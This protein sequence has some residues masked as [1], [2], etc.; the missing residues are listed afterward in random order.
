M[1]LARGAH[2]GIRLPARRAVP[3]PR[4]IGPSLLVIALLSSPAIRAGNLDK[5]YLFNI[6]SQRLDTALLQFGAQTHVQISFASKATEGRAWT[7]RLIGNYTGQKALAELLRGSHLGFVVL[8]N[9]IEIVPDTSISSKTPDSTPKQ[10]DPISKKTPSANGLNGPHPAQPQPTNPTT[11][12]DS[13]NKPALKEIVITGSRLPTS[14]EYGPQEVQIYGAL[15]LD[16]S[17]QTSI[18]QFLSTLPGVSV[19]SPEIVTNYTSTVRLRGLPIGT[20]LVLLD[21]R[22]IEQSGIANGGYFDLS[23]IPMAAI[24]T[25]EVDENG[26]SA[27]YGSDALA[28]VVNIIL[29]NNLDGFSANVKYGWAKDLPYLHTNLAFGRQWSQGGWSVLG[30][31]ESDGT[32]LNSERALS[33]SNDYSNFGGPNNNYPECAPGNVFSTSGSALPGAPAGSGA[34]YAAISGLSASGKPALSQFTYGSLNQCSLLA[35]TSLLPE[36]RRAA[37]LLRGHLEITSSLELF[38]ETLYTHM[39]RDAAVGYADLFGIPGYQQ[40]TVSPSNPYNPFGTTVGVG[41]ALPDVPLP[42]DFDTDFFRPLVGLKGTVADRWQWE[43]SGWQSSDWTRLVAPNEFPNISAIQAALNSSNPAMALN[44]FVTGPIGSQTLIGSLFGDETA[45]AMGRDR[46]AEF[47]VRGAM[48]RLPA[49]SVQAV[50]G[51]DYARSALYENAGGG[52]GV[53]AS[54]N[55]I[56]YY[57]RRYSAVFGE[58]QIP[59]L[60][61]YA[62]SETQAPLLIATI[63]GRHDQYSDFGGATTEQYGLEIRPA[64]SVLVRATY[65]TAFDAPSLLDLY[66]PKQTVD[67]LVIDPVTGAPEYVPVITGGN[68]QLRPLGGRSHTVGI[69]YS[70]GDIQGLRL[71]VTQWQ[72]VE[73]SA[74]QAFAA[75]VVVDNQSLFPG[76]VIRDSSGAIV[77]V[78]DTEANFGVIDVGGI[79]YGI[80]YSHP[81]ARGVI[82]CALDAT[83][84]YHYKQ[85]LSPGAPP[86]EAD[87]IAEDDGNWA[88]RWKGTVGL[89]WSDG[90]VNAHLDGRYTGEYLDYDSSRPIGNFWLVDTNLRVSIAGLVRTS[91]PWLRGAYVEAGATN[92]LNKAPQ[93]S[94]YDFDLYGYDAAQMSIVGRSMYVSLGVDW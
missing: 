5:V 32:L 24:Q 39:T 49:G 78:D 58:A 90:G 43:L 4:F 82:S 62:R 74:I 26:S 12:A 17:G 79:D 64:Q 81:L 80:D 50:V 27:I 86:I 11:A 55:S 15:Q 16:Q 73:T 71:L 83:Q 75:Q 8:G 13:G 72:V 45:K 20:T 29:K 57:R 89:G 35:G 76:R 34:T 87:G 77:E 18:S 31:Y 44:P 60:R 65:G 88:P 85:A 23:N 7:T 33:A 25:V 6:R 67:S 61:G 41:A 2:K 54:F 21:G 93:F 38:S 9:T 14:S 1:I 47:Y 36:T 69:V 94:N 56:G 52:T 3:R 37:V 48:L 22:R 51:G 42:E 70:S 59:L 66:S 10:A 68:S 63:S 19:S 53:Y 84:T 30:S 40:F 91:N 28:G 92:L 46:S